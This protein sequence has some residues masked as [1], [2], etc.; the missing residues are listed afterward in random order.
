MAVVFV[1]LLLSKYV[2]LFII[3]Y[4]LTFVSSL[5]EMWVCSQRVGPRISDSGYELDRSSRHFAALLEQ[6]RL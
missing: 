1:Y 3:T 4:V 6:F 2:R 5:M